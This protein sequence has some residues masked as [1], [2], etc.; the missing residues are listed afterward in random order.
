MEDEPKLVHVSGD[1]MAAELE[2]LLRR[3]KAGE[4]ITGVMRVFNSDGTWQD[5]VFGESEEEKAALL[6]E[7][8]ALHKRNMQ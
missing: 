4:P 8:Q 1:D 2:E 5:V 7:F 6:V 3:A